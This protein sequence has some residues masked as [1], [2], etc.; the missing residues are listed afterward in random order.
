MSTETTPDEMH[1]PRRRAVATWGK[2]ALL[3]GGAGVVVNSVLLG[4]G[5][6]G[7]PGAGLW[8]AIAGAGLVLASIYLLLTDRRSEVEGLTSNTW[9]VPVALLSLVAFGIALAYL[10]LILPVFALM[11]IWLRVLGNE[12]WGLAVGLAASTAIV[13]HL[14]FVTGLEVPFPPDFL[15]TLLGLE[16]A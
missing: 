3:L 16:G 11:V 2:V 13:L 12:P 4:L 15:L 8:P 10:G 1:D 9:K 5:S 7:A 6:L 14:L